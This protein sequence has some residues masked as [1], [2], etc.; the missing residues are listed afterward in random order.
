MKLAHTVNHTPLTHHS[1]LGKRTL[2]RNMRPGLGWAAPLH[3]IMHCA[4]PGRAAWK[5]VPHFCV[6]AGPGACAAHAARPVCLLIRGQG[7]SRRWEAEIQ[8]GRSVLIWILGKE[9][10]VIF[11]NHTTLEWL[12]F[13]FFQMLYTIL[14]MD[15]QTRH[16]FTSVLHT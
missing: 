15:P 5:L 12:N 13:C 6:T 1:R 9:E 14:H 8:S 4:S 10:G 2:I 16:P 7:R 11:Q 3:F